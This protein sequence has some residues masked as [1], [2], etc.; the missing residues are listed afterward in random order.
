MKLMMTTIA[1]MMKFFKKAS[2]RLSRRLVEF[3]S[4]FIL[5]SP[6]KPYLGSD[7]MGKKSCQ[8]LSVSVIVESIKA[9]QLFSI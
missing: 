7:Q 4:H 5:I 8:C 1:N 6:E 3:I 9:F 2:L